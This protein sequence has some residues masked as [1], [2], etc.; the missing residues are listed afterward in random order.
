M[1]V[2]GPA[3]IG[4]SR[5]AW[6]FLKYIDGL[7]EAVYWHSGRSP[8]YG[9]GITSGRWARW[10][11][12]RAG[13]VE[14]DDEPTTRAKVARD[15]RRVRHRRRRADVDRACPADPA[16]R[17]VG[18]GGRRSSSAPGERSSSASPRQGTV[19]LVFEDMHFADTGLLDFIDHLLEWSRGL[20]IYIVTLPGRSCSSERPTGAPASATSRR[21]ISSRWPKRTCASCWRAWCPG[22]PRPRSAAIVARADGIPLY[23][24]ETVRML[25][26]RRPSRRARAAYTCRWATWRSGRAGD[27]DGA[28]RRAPRHPRSDRS[29]DRP[30]RR[31]AGPELH[32]WR[33]W[34]RCRASRGGSRAA[35]RG[36]RPARAASRA[37]SDPRSPERGQYAFVQALIREVAYN[38]LSKKD[39]KTLPSCGGALLRVSWASDELVGA[40]AGHYLAAHANAR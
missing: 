31:G 9:E 35:A 33:R 8:A 12:S 17:R 38:T 10:S 34:P 24:V 20:P 23:A 27:A 22:C 14:S 21:S 18:H 39:R 13:L 25:L 1:S 2:I 29:T 32:A 30:R 26:A 16:W 37:R 28:D 5:L 15:G 36:A 19:V 40:L 7:V 4:K 6:E 3:G 11:A